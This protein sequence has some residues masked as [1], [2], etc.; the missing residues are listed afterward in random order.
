MYHVDV[1]ESVNTCECAILRSSYCHYTG[2]RGW[3]S[4][5]G[6]TSYKFT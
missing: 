6:R 3:F 5:Y 4:Q 2:S 1:I